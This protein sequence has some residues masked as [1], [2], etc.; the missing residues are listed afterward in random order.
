MSQ[1]SVPN[2]K[3]L[4]GRRIVATGLVA[5]LAFIGWL[6]FRTHETRVIPPT[7]VVV[8]DL[9][10]GIVNISATDITITSDFFNN[11][12]AIECAQGELWVPETFAWIR[13]SG[14]GDVCYWT[15]I[16]VHPAGFR[17]CET[18]VGVCTAEVVPRFPVRPV[19]VEFQLSPISSNEDSKVVMTGYLTK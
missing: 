12:S 8:K 1:R 4:I 11:V 7:R 6:L 9:H 19:Y 3:G 10:G 13:S 2:K 15:T 17:P 16:N 5:I 14:M 18:Q